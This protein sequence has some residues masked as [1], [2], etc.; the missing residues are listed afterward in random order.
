MNRRRLTWLRAVGAL[1]AVLALVA[2][3][4]SA[5]V[6]E[7]KR[8][9]TFEFFGWEVIDRRQVTERGENVAAVSWHYEVLVVG[10]SD[11][12]ICCDAAL[13]PLEWVWNKKTHS[14]TVSGTWRSHHYFEPSSWEGH[15]SGRMSD[16][17][18]EGI[19]HLTELHSGAKFHGRWTSPPVDPLG[20]GFDGVINPWTVTGSGTVG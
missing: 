2:A 16:V 14:G 15:F 8:E 10:S 12:S 18:G 1:L 9:L 3:L 7:G 19:I 13:D 20:G 4:P 5:A 17:G 11:F 6:G